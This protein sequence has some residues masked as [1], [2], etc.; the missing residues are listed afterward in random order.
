MLRFVLGAYGVLAAIALYMFFA[1]E[2]PLG[3]CLFIFIYPTVLFLTYFYL[4][5]RQSKD[6]VFQARETCQKILDMTRS[7][8]CFPPFDD[9]MFDKLEEACGGQPLCDMSGYITGPEEGG[10]TNVV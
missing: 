1:L 2:L 9:K 7:N 3:N 10:G 4:V 5:W 6:P 8:D